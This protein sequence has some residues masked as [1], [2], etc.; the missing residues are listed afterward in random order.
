MDTLG[1]LSIVS[2]ANLRVAPRFWTGY[3]PWC[4]VWTDALQLINN[5]IQVTTILAKKFGYFY[6]R[7]CWKNQW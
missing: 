4:A 7:G 2:G 3:E 5:N 6:G 1:R